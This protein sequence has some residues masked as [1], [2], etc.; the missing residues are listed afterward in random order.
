MKTGSFQLPPIT[1]GV[2]SS[3]FFLT[4]CFLLGAYLVDGGVVSSDTVKLSLATLVGSVIVVGALA[5]L[6]LGLSI[7]LATVV[8]FPREQLFQFS[9]PLLGGGLKPTDILFCAMFLGWMARAF[10][11]RSVE[12]SHVP[13]VLTFLLIAFVTWAVFSAAYGI[14][15][16]VNFK[17]SLYEL[18][19]LLQYLLFF[20]I[21]TELN[22]RSVQRLIYVILA[23]S[24]AI[25]IKAVISFITGEGGEA[26]YTGGFTRVMDIEFSYLLFSILISL[27]VYIQRL[28]RPIL[29]LACVAINLG[30]LAVT[31]QRS[32]FLGMGAAFLFL[33]ILSD[34]RAKKRFLNWGLAVA[35][36][37]LLLFPLFAVNSS[38]ERNFLL[39]LRYRLAS[40]L[41]YKADDSAQHRFEEWTA[42]SNIIKAHPVTGGGLGLRIQFYSPLYSEETNTTG[43]WSDDF[44]MHNSYIWVATKMGVTG[45]LLF[46]SLIFIA[47][48]HAILLSRT[49]NGMERAQVLSLAVS[50]IALI[51]ISL[52][53]PMFNTPNLTPFV[54]FTFGGICINQ[55]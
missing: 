33:F 7:L 1:A 45:L 53:G 48:R 36:I 44:Y 46:L 37:L 38:E 29:L 21:V 15:E 19:P 16:G 51:V 31:F 55:K 11:G 42:A 54:A 28:G 22:R 9:L 50:L 20:P 25:A 26:S 34:H 39:A 14:H 2:L 47:L 17:D 30:G 41:D 8:L 3:L 35:T 6:E 49:Y 27:T 18:R 52:F 23:A 12:M 10:N 43:Y 4:S 32:A 5:S 13:R 40:V 24:V